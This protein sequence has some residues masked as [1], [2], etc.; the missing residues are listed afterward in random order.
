MKSIV[1]A[2]ALAGLLFV[3]SSTQAQVA[4][5]SGP[6][7]GSYA[8]WSKHAKNNNE[9]VLFD[10]NLDGV[11]GDTVRTSTGANAFS[12]GFCDGSSVVATPA[13]GCFKDNGG[14][15]FGARAGYDLQFGSF[16]VGALIEGSRLDVHD[17]VT[18]FSSTPASY[19]LKRTLKYQ[20]AVRA[21]AGFA[22]NNTLIYGT[23][24]ATRG[25]IEHH[26]SST[27]SANSFPR[28]RKNWQNGW[29]AGGGIEHQFFPNL[30]FG[31][32]YLYTRYDDGDGF[33][34]R[35]GGPVPA[36]NPFIQV[37]SAG[38]SFRRSQDKMNIHSFRVTTAYRF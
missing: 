15:E 28:D 12:P 22:M 9:T 21:R 7:L 27:N 6:Y 2:A 14:F 31:A 32:E 25:Q 19:T 13:A 4:D 5:W 20:G 26:F 36:N 30:T 3:G 16:V 33:D 24:G 1:G 11:Y 29:Q 8:G 38:T 17:D 37:N 34:L 18:A 10:T 23:G 35:A